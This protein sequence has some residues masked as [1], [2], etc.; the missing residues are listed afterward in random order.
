MLVIENA[1]VSNQLK[2]AL[3]F[4][5]SKDTMTARFQLDDLMVIDTQTTPPQKIYIREL[6]DATSHEFQSSRLSAEEK[7]TIIEA[8]GLE[9]LIG[10]L[11]SCFQGKGGEYNARQE[12]DYTWWQ[13]HQ[14]RI[15][16]P[17]EE[18]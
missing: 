1:R 14:R 8:V 5:A 17:A 4:H 18:I 10:M 9:P 3:P 15:P 13:L 7:I 16:L 6:L 12:A 2:F 11:D